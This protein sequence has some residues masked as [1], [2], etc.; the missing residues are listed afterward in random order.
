MIVFISGRMDGLP[1][2][3]RKSFEEAEA[4]LKRMGHHVLN[5]ARLPIGMPK[6]KYMPICFS[7]IDQADAVYML[8]GFNDSWG[9]KIEQEYAAYQRKKIVYEF[10]EVWEEEQEE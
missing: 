7:M 5:P 9:S 2:Y 1:D 3:G 10:Y 8:K 4:R 6:E